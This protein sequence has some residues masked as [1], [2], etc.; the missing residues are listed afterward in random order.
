MKEGQRRGV[1]IFEIGILELAI[2]ADRGQRKISRKIPAEPKG[3]SVGLYVIAR[4]IRRSA[5]KV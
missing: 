2:A 4:G 3:D 5:D 1:R